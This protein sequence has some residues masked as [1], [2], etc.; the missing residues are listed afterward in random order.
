MAVRGA[1]VRLL[2]PLGLL[3]RA[4]RS[5]FRPFAE[6]LS[7][8]P[9]VQGLVLDAYAASYRSRSQVRMLSGESRLFTRSVPAIRQIRAG[10]RCRRYR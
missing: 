2:R 7:D 10:R 5:S 3:E 6:R 4:I 1:S 9:R 8:D